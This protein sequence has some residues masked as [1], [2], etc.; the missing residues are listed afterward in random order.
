L[1]QIWANDGILKKMASRGAEHKAN[2]S[3]AIKT[4]RWKGLRQKRFAEVWIAIQDQEFS[5]RPAEAGT[6]ARM[7]GMAHGKVAKVAIGE[8]TGRCAEMV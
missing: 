1:A 2:H 6:S 5:R 4:R 7:P 8:P 3:C